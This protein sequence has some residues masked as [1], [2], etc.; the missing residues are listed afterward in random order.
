MFQPTR[1]TVL[2]IGGTA[3]AT[4]LLADLTGAHAAPL[5]VGEPEPEQLR[6]RWVDA[7][8][9]RANIT[10]SP[11]TFADAI[12]RL[13]RRADALLAGVSPTPTR[14]FTSHDWAIGATEIAKSNEMR[15]NYAGLETLAIAWA[16]PTSAHEGSPEVLRA[17]VDGLAHLHAT[18]YHPGTDWWGN[19]WSWL[20]GATKPL[21]NVMAI[22]HD[23]LDRSAIDD[24]CAAMDHFLPDRDPR[25]QIHPSGVQES[26]GANR[27]DI[28]QAYIVRAIVQPD[29]DLLRAAVDALSP[30]WRYVTEG[31]GF[32]R[33]GSFIQH[34]TVPYTGTYGLV[35]LGGLAKLFALLAGSSFDITDD[36]RS[37]VTGVVEASFAPFMFHGQM[38][39]AVRGRAVARYAERSVDDGN[40]LIEH[41]LRLAE[42]ADPETAERWRGLCRQ[43][44]ESNDIASI[45]E[46]TNIVR[47]ALVTELL[48]SSVPAVDDPIGPRHFPAMDRLVH[49]G[50]DGTWAMAVAMCSDRIAWHEGTGAEN[51]AGVKTS[52]GMTYLYLADDDDHF[53]DHFWATSDLAAPPGT[54]VDL[55]PLPPN[56]EGEWGERTPANE[57]TGGAVLGD[58]GLAAMHLVAPGGTGL[59]AR[60]AWFTLPEL[61]ALVLALS[62]YTASFI[63]ETV[64]A[65]ILAVSH[66]QI[67]AAHAL[68][69]KHGQTLR[70]VVI[71]QA[72]RVIIPPLTSQYL[73]LTKNSSLA[74]AIGYPD[75]VSVFAGTVLNQTGQ[76]VE[77]IT[78]TMAVY[79]T[80]SLSISLFMNWYNRRTALVER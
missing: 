32:Y 4:A 54:T 11:A 69:L 73:N 41:V 5:A 72:L 45:T 47:L 36:S 30:T 50:D 20:I 27:V 49:R 62:I 13:D 70:L 52:Q 39:D 74:V 15:M 46:T 34:T 61:V 29:T 48:G 31:N 22:V 2:R 79:L 23:E 24:Y 53:D 38:M 3:F 59:E 63:A 78:I 10:A 21:A 77:C 60:K 55:T 19:W 16:T 28:C 33:D 9:G 26:E 6:L 1:R 35:L 75:L 58:V 18:V 56:P 71:P 43:W 65:G 64:R 44:I 51:F 14:Y 17:I 57:W 42:A 68:G 80:I 7:L 25:L 40:D 8:T 66:G 12:A 76:A 67:E 37:N